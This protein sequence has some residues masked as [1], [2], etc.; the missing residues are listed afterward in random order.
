MEY[1]FSYLTLSIAFVLG[2]IIIFYASQ[3]PSYTQNQIP[4]NITN[5]IPCN[6][7]NFNVIFRYGIAGAKYRNELNTFNCTFIKDMVNK[8]P[9]K[10]RL[11]LND[12][13]L[14]A[15]YEKMIEIDFFSY[16][17]IFNYMPSGNIIG[18]STP[19]SIFYLEVRNGTVKH[20][21][22]WNDRYVSDGNERYDNLLELAHLI[23][24]I[25]IAKPE[26]QKLPEP[27]AAYA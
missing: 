19:Y 20:S 27:S 21:V 2:V 24:T 16:P 8:P 3:L 9:I 25:I 15:I 14:E 23:K 4:N 18:E 13:E 12:E 22:V 10:T 1:K 26:Y 17:Q 5:Q 7:T 6:T 11:Y